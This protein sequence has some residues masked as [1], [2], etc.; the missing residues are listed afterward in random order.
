MV[1]RFPPTKSDYHY[2]SKK[3]DFHYPSFSGNEIDIIQGFENSNELFN[4]KSYGNYSVANIDQQNQEQVRSGSYACQFIDLETD[5]AAKLGILT[6]KSDYS[7]V[8]TEFYLYPEKLNDTTGQ[9]F[10]FHMWFQDFNNKLA[11]YLNNSTTVAYDYTLVINSVENGNFNTKYTNNIS[12]NGEEWNKINITVKDNGNFSYDINN[13]N[14]TD[15]GS[16]NSNLTKSGQIEYYYQ[17]L[18]NQRTKYYIDDIE[19]NRLE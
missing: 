7:S 12:L 19:I 4:K 10:G 16:I 8:E 14:Y 1:D 11:I 5:K 13:G 15:S 6:D 17:S 2:P 18:N 9:G 3:L